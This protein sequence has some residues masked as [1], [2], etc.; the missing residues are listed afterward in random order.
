MFFNNCFDISQKRREKM[1][2]KRH[3]GVVSVTF[4][5][6]PPN[7]NSMASRVK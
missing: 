5:I 1:D 2:E 3:C 4:I 7:S 6:K